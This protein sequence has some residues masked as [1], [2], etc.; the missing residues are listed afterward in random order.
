M[1]LHAQLWRQ[2][3]LGVGVISS[4]WRRYTVRRPSP[5][6][7]AGFDHQQQHVDQ[8]AYRRHTTPSPACQNRC[9]LLPVLRHFWHHLNSRT[10]PVLFVLMMNSA[11]YPAT[12]CC[13]ILA[14][15]FGAN[16]DY[17]SE[18]RMAY[19][20]DLR[21]GACTIGF[22]FW[23]GFAAFQLR[24]RMVF[25]RSTLGPPKLTGYETR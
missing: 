20:T 11:A 22:D 25:R 12:V 1:L 23:L 6:M 24:L 8:P 14:P 15:A 7:A 16:V 13:R 17:T 10:A 9:L 21:K 5:R 3:A 4:R 2:S 19:S 18:N